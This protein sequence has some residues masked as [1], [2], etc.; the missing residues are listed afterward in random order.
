VAAGEVSPV[1]VGDTYCSVAEACTELFDLRRVQ[2]WTSG[3][4]AWCDAQPELVA[5]RGQCMV[6]RAEQ[7]LD[8]GAERDGLVSAGVAG[9]CGF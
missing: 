8:V 9:A 3:L 5:F 2:A 7:A 4:S 1:I 6:H